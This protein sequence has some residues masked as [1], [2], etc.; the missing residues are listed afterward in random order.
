M[1]SDKATNMDL[2]P[3]ADIDR[4]LHAPAR[5]MILAILNV[6][7]TA[8]FTFLMKQTGL[9]RGNLGTHVM[10]LEEDKY[11]S[12]KKVFVERK[13][14][15]LYRLTDEGRRAIQTYR[16]NMRHVIDGLLS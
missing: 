7:E 4:T 3:I 5:L 12:V 2:Q 11:I 16:K 8:D 13:P 15:T 10:K 9:T 14:R 6:V 1:P